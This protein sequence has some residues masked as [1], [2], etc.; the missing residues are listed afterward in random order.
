MNLRK[1][2]ILFV[3]TTKNCLSV[4]TQFS[5]P[6]FLVNS[7]WLT[8]SLKL[9][10]IVTNENPKHAFMQLTTYNITTNSISDPYG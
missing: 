2:L 8:H 10:L 5:Q 9:K 3:D 4:D 7:I 6:K 1:C